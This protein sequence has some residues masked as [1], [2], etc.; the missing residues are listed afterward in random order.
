MITPH[1]KKCPHRCPKVD[2]AVSHY[3]LNPKSMSWDMCSLNLECSISMFFSN[4][5]W[6]LFIMVQEPL[7]K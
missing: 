2:D 3:L 7:A 6:M 1:S 4:Q 5:V